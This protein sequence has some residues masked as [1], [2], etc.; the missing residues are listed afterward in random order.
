M[1]KVTVIFS[2]LVASLFLV[3][4]SVMAGPDL[5]KSHKGK[6]CNYCHVSPAKYPK[7][8]NAGY[9]KGGA[10]HKSLSQDKNCSGRGCH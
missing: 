3:S 6:T 8:K 4:T 7:T 9:K 1:K 5:M 10:K 2:L